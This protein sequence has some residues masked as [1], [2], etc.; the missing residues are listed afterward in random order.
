MSWYAVAVLD[1]AFDATKAF[2]TPLDAR[3]WLKLAL[4]VF[5][6]GN[7]GGGGGGS[8]ASTGSSTSPGTPGGPPGPTGIETDLPAEF[9]EFLPILVGVVA[10]ALVVG[11]LYA[12]VGSVMEFVFVESLRRRRVRIRDYAGQHTGQ[13]VQLFVFRVLLGLLVAL[14]ALG[15]VAGVLSLAGIA[16]ALPVGLLVVLAPLLIL[17]GIAVAI[18]DGFTVNF[19]VP[20]MILKNVGVAAGWKRFWPTLTRDWKQYGVYALVRVGLSFAVGVLASIIGGVV[21]AVLV[22]PLVVVGIFAVPALG[23]PAGL[24]A[25]PLAVAVAVLLVLS[26]FVLLTA[27]L[28]VVFV[29]VQTYLRYHS[30]LVLGDTDRDFDLIPE[31][32]REIRDAG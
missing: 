24:L 32:R 9:G 21:G 30:L 16:P 6:L 1:D 13:A 28:A 12:L 22:A 25:N 3:Q 5:F 4:V 23:G 8:S 20:V 18:V 7:A 11:L 19:V 31:L 14:P 15:V 29:P 2:L 17:V 26:Y 27:T 10:V